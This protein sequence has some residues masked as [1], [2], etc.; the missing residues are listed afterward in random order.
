[1]Y[2]N[3]AKAEEAVQAEEVVEEIRDDIS[4]DDDD[5]REA[6]ERSAVET[7]PTNI[8]RLSAISN[9]VVKPALEPGMFSAALGPCERRAS[10]VFSPVDQ[11]V[12]VG[13]V[14]GRSSVGRSDRDRPRGRR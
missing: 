8:R 3:E 1:M 12:A 4:A 2:N 7:L 6:R 9:V 5:L 11:A 13:A 10:I 14:R